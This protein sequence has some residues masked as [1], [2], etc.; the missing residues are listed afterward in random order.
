MNTIKRALVSVSDKTGLIDFVSGL[1]ELIPNLQI[2]STG[3][4]AK[5]LQTKE[6]S[7][8]PISEVTR[9]P[10]ILDGRVKTLHPLIHGGLLGVRANNAH[11]EQMSKLGIEPIDLAVVNLYPFRNTILKPNSSLED[12]IENIDIGGPT[13]IRAAAKNYTSVVVVTE[14]SL[15]PSILEELKNTGKISLLTREKLAIEAFGHTSQYDAMI[16]S[17]LQRSIG[18]KED[19]PPMITRAFEKM[20]V[21]LRYGENPHQK[22]NIYRDVTEAMPSTVTDAKQLQ[23]K[24]LSY[25]NVLDFDAALEILF[26]FEEPTAVIIKHMNPCGIASTDTITNAYI[27]AH[28]TDPMSAFGSIIGINRPLE[29][30]ILA[31][32]L[33]DTFVEGIIAPA[34]N[35]ELLP[36]LSSKLN[37]RVLET[38]EPEIKLFPKVFRAIN[39]G[40]LIQDR[41]LFRISTDNFKVVTKRAPTPEEERDLQFA[42]K[43]VKHVKSNAIVL[44]K[45]RQACGIG[46]GQMSRVDSAIIARRKA[47]ENKFDL[48]KSVLA[49]DAFFPFRDSVDTAAEAG[50]TAII[51]PGGSIRDKESIQAANEHDIAM[52]FTGIRC[53][54]H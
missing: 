35:K 7:V 38:G 29:D 23:G 14:P 32:K 34:V 24:A 20:T 16:H 40:L 49:S 18:S 39:G 50:I 10:E 2:I 13:I 12:A 36:I 46:A 25:V 6:I 51:Q 31:K 1:R 9:F 27:R 42:W 4:T 17:Y 3:G 33:T 43:V 48:K 45:N 28:E 53:F 5:L 52:V 11:R 8:T 15:Y 47:L 19:F 22:A 54:K 44:A 37:M 21:N 30:E 26:E 41:D